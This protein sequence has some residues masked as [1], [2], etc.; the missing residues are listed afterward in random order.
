MVWKWSYY[1][2]LLANTSR[3]LRQMDLFSTQQ[4][5]QFLMSQAELRSLSSLFAAIGLFFG[6]VILSYIIHSMNK[7]QSLAYYGDKEA[8]RHLILPC[9]KPLLRAI[10]ASFISLALFVLIVG[11]IAANPD[12]TTV[13]ITFIA[14]S[15]SA[16]YAIPTLLL[17]QPSVS[18]NGFWRTGTSLFCW[19]ILSVIVLFACLFNDSLLVSILLI[20]LISLMPILLTAGILLRILPSRVQLSSHSNR[21]SVELLFVYSILFLAILVSAL[22]SL[23]KAVTSL[24]LSLLI[25]FSSQ[26]FP[27]ALYK[28]LLAD[29]KF[30]RGLGKHNR[31]GITALTGRDR[32]VSSLPSVT[33]KVVEFEFQSVLTD[34][35]EWFIDFAFIQIEDLIGVGASARVYRGKFKSENVAIKVHTPPELTAQELQR[36]RKEALINSNLSHPCIVKFF[37][38]CIRPPEIGIIIE[39]CENGNLH[40]SL[41]T[42]M[43]EWTPNRRLTA[44]LDAAKAVEYL[45]SRGFMHRDIKADNYFVTFNWKVK[46][47]DL[48]EATPIEN[49]DAVKLSK[50]RMTILGTIAYMAPELVDGKNFYS[51]AIDVYALSMTLWQI[52]TGLDPYEGIG[53]FDLYEAITSGKR[54][55]LSSSAPDELNDAIAAGWTANSSER[56]SAAEIVRRL[57]DFMDATERARGGKQIGASPPKVEAKSVEEFDVKALGNCKFIEDSSSFDQDDENPQGSYSPPDKHRKR[58]LV[59]LRNNILLKSSGNPLVR[60]SFDPAQ[61]LIGPDVES[62]HHEGQIGAELTDDDLY[63]SYGRKSITEQSR[64]PLI[65]LVSYLRRLSV[66]R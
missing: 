24:L 54:P 60:E 29:T 56:I 16:L 31:G 63:Q 17:L 18:R 61:D 58:P 49:E 32:G 19:W 43:A 53:T 35:S 27:I 10:W 40:E 23:S 41:L 51:E 2:F 62:G 22:L 52:W 66:K 26:L 55:E 8:A 50:E 15:C 39:F 25:F 4:I 1:L 42:H 7:N 36:I 44:I 47:G 37:G 38:I 14:M 21:L 9:Y 46:L 20:V 34:T 45:H 57:K 11:I 33:M 64:N 28:S 6:C 13:L 48:G 5:L 65:P 30:W 3:Q 12:N 59:M